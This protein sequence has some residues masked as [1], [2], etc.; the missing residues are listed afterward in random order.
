MK[1]KALNPASIPDS[2][3]AADIVVGIT[4]CS[5]LQSA[6]G[7]I[8]AALGGLRQAAAGA[9]AL[10]MVVDPGADDAMAEAVRDVQT[11][12]PNL[13]VIYH[14]AAPAFRHAVA[15][16]GI[17]GRETGLRIILEASQQLNSRACVLLSGDISAVPSEWFVRMLGP[18]LDGGYDYVAPVYQRQRYEGALSQTMLNPLMQ[19]LYG[20]A[21]LQPLVQEAAFSQAVVKDLLQDR[22]WQSKDLWP[23]LDLWRA[24][25]LVA[26]GRRPCQTVIGPVA[27]QRGLQSAGV[28]DMLVQ[29]AG[30]AFSMM[31]MYGNAWKRSN[32]SEIPIMGEYL[33]LNPDT[34]QTRPD[35]MIERF[36]LG[37]K[38]FMKLWSLFITKEVRTFLHR[39][40]LKPNAQINIP[41]EVWA[42]IVLSFALAY[43]KNI[44]NRQH[45]L[46]TLTPLYLGKTASFIKE[47]VNLGHQDFMAASE[48]MTG[49]YARM[50]YFLKVNWTD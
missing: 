23:A 50:K 26:G 42:E 10:I 27:R 31:D 15:Y 35:Q 5:S 48:R 6:S 49:A 47:T 4:N 28:T 24:T 14:A 46:Q 30:G 20:R 11:G 1:E 32:P 17:E 3:G 12:D 19:S 22:F 16:H 39:E 29:L 43:H 40:A 38:E 7:L 34:A 13:T 25:A 45:L 44:M 9:R 2:V 36:R 37:V 18:L 8:H 33:D 21:L 41:D